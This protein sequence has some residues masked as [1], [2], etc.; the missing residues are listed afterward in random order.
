MHEV[1]V[2][3]AHA[4]DELDLL[5]LSLDSPG[6]IVPGPLLVAETGGRVHAALSLSSGDHLASDS[7]LGDRLVALLR[8]HAHQLALEADVP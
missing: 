2:R 5:E 1:R 6:G 8:F 3:R 7:L 4:R